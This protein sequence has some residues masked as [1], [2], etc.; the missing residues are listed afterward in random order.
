MRLR[1]ILPNSR[2]GLLNSKMKSAFQ[3]PP[4]FS[5]ILNNFPFPEIKS[6][7][8]V[9]VLCQGLKCSHKPLKIF[10]AGLMLP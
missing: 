10:N 9:D 1:M 6:S 8:S 2:M 7:C 4:L 5:F 3:R